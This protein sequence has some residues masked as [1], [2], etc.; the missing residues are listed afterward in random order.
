MKV[1]IVIEKHGTAIGRLAEMTVKA[2]PWHEYRIVDVHPKR[3]TVE[4]LNAFEQ[5]QEW[6]DVIDFRYWKTAEL[7]RAHYAIR[8]PCLLTHYN[9]YDLEK[10][11]W[12]EYQINVVVNREQ[13][14]ILKHASTLVPLPIDLDY[15]TFK[16]TAGEA[17]TQ[18]D[19][20]MV[21]NRIEGKKG[22]L[23][24]AKLCGEHGYSMV[25]VG[26]ISDPTYFDEVIR[27]G[28]GHI[29]QKLK[30][31]NDELRDLYHQSLMHISNSVDNFESGTMPTLEAMACGTPVLTRRTG[32]VPDI[33][34]GRNLAVRK[35]TQDDENELNTMIQ[36]I[37]H[38]DKYRRELAHEGRSSL[39]SRTLDV[40]G[41]QMSKLYH[42]VRGT[43]DLVSVIVPTTA[44]PKDLAKTLAHIMAIPVP[45]LEIIVCDDTP[46]PEENEALVA[47]VRKQTSHTIKF[48]AVATYTVNLESTPHLMKTYG[49]ARARNRGILEAE[50]EWIMFVDDRIHVE[51]TALSAFQAKAR[52]GAWLWGV[53]DAKPKG[54]V[55]NFS[56]IRRADIIRIGGFNEQIGQYG[57]MT[58]EVRTRAEQNKIA[59][60]I[61]E[62]ANAKSAY[63]SKSKWTKYSAIAKS[64]AQ[65]YK[66]Y[67]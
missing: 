62:S 28:N 58:Q 26:A 46:K 38:D 1:A 24:V 47:E 56:F 20:I 35:S 53:K 29:T 52:A 22:I 17:P 11:Q 4:Q 43:Q 15:W 9:P 16:E 63:K 51:V 13:Q 6:C 67:G 60:E 65:C 14:M 57:G 30:I 34:N 18:Y 41:R 66:L 19:I 23:P 36:E 37:L 21:A 40:Y 42:Q 5:A 31:S 45:D 49:L 33:F 64:K 8:K 12:S 61:V 59:F 10:Q 7:L 27:A 25:L 39:R 54:F 55:E 32:H 2:A 50:G 48:Y 3:P 44:D